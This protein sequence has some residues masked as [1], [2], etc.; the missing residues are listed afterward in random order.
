MGSARKLLIR[1]GFAARVRFL[2]QARTLLAALL[3]LALHRAFF[4]ANETHGLNAWAICKLALYLLTGAG[5]IGGFIAGY[6]FRELFP[7]VKSKPKK[8]IDV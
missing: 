6:Y 4:D 3:L 2:C 8:P 5:S 1:K 7:P